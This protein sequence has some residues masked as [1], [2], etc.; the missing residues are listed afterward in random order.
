MCKQPTPAYSSHGGAVRIY[1]MVRELAR[2]YDVE[3]LLSEGPVET[4]DLN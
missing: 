3:I 4:G 2:E 1:N